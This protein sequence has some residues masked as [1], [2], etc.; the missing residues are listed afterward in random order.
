MRCSH[1]VLWSTPLLLGKGRLT[2]LVSSFPKSLEVTQPSVEAQ[3]Q[4][5]KTGPNGFQ[6]EGRP[7]TLSEF[8]S[9]A[10]QP[11]WPAQ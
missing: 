1:P 6:P 7:G 5:Q 10:P 3:P 8:A 9:L 4:A 2:E 11:R